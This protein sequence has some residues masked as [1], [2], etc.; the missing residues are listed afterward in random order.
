MLDSMRLK[1][2]SK[3]HRSIGKWCQDFRSNI[4]ERIHSWGKVIYNRKHY[5]ILGRDGQRWS[6]ISFLISFFIFL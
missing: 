6:M 1:T 3:P 2:N 5:E 4:D